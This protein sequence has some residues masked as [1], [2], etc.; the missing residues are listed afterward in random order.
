MPAC[1]KNTK[2]SPVN[3]TAKRLNPKVN[4]VPVHDGRMSD[5]AMKIAVCANKNERC[6]VYRF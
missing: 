1:L 5:I 4:W 3:T 2:P 6:W